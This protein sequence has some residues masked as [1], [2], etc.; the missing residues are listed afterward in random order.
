M[1][2]K[3][4]DETSK[5]RAPRL[6]DVARAAGVSPATASRALHGGEREVREANRQRVLEAAEKLGYTTNLAAQTIARGRSRGITLIAKVPDDYANPIFAGVLAAAGRRNLPITFT[7]A[8]PSPTD[9]IESINIARSIRSEVLILGGTLYT[10]DS[11]VPRLVEALRRFESEGGRVVIISQP[12]LPFD[13]VSYSNFDSSKE[14]A[15][16]LHGLG[17]RNFAVVT[18]NLRGHTPRERTEGFTAGLAELGIELTPDRVVAG[19]FT[20]DSAYALTG[21]LLRRGVPVDAIFGVNDA[22]ALGVLAYL[23]DSGRSGE[24]AVAGFDDMQAL[25]DVTPS[26]TTVHLPWDQVAEQALELAFSASGPE[27]RRAM[28]NGH[29]IVRESTPEKT[30]VRP[31]P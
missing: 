28:V 15:A 31:Q 3:L 17:Y 20:R 26:L 16:A 18:G 2:K 12:G 8:G 29:V 21:E 7:S 19:E 4:V 10:N 9:A 14:M 6:A 13:T 5:P 23:R 24:I 1:S 22:M 27:P 30:G 11:S 25:R